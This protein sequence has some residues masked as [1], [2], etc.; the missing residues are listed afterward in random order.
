MRPAQAGI[1][2]SRPSQRS[3]LL[4]PYRFTSAVDFGENR[5][6]LKYVLPPV[7]L[8]AGLYL[9][10][11]EAME[12]P[13]DRLIHHRTEGLDMPD[14]RL[15]HEGGLR[16]IA[17]TDFTLTIRTVGTVVPAGGRAGRRRPVPH[18][19][20][21]RRRLGA[22]LPRGPGNHGPRGVC[23]RHTRIGPCA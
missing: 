9:A 13:T 16:T 17:R 3:D 11:P 18:G 10:L 1:S 12:A 14:F 15:V 5:R 23:P 4:R 21:C 22:H 20:Q 7:A 19:T 2:S 8:F 6:Y